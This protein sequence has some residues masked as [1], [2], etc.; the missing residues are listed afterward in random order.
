MTA[1]NA[2]P[3]ATRERLWRWAL[4]LLPG[5]ALVLLRG[6][7]SNWDLR[8]YHLYNPHAWLNGRMLTDIAPAQLQT[9][10][11]PL[12]DT[13]FYLLTVSGLD[14]RWASVWLT[15]PFAV[16]IYLLLGLHASLSP[17]RPSRCSQIVLA[18][19]AL[20]GAAFWSTLGNSM[21]D[22]FVAAA[23]LGALSL[24]LGPGQTRWRPWLWG[25]L[26]AGAMAGLKLTA[27]SYCIAL[28]VAALVPV[29]GRARLPALLALAAG[30]LLGFL[31]SYGWW[32]GTLYSLTRNPFFPYFNN[33]FHSSWLGA[34]D[35]ADARF[36]VHGLEGLLLAPFQLLRSSPLFSELYLRDPR[37]LLGLLGLG[38]LVLTRRGDVRLRQLAAFFFSAFIV[39]ALQYGIYRYAL[40]L[41]L[42]ASLAL[43]LCLQQLPRRWALVALIAAAVIVNVATKRQNWGHVH[44]SSPR[45]GIGAAPLLKDAM[46]IIAG[47]E[48]VAYLA[49]GLPDSTPMVA[50]ANNILSPGDCSDLQR[51]AGAAITRHEGS[52]WL[53]SPDTGHVA[54]SLAL[55]RAHYGL[56]SAGACLDYVSSLERAQLCPLKRVS[57]PPACR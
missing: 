4:A 24:V 41:E 3:V 13:P 36:R 57:G 31:V 42:L 32:G 35:F 55:L 43:V 25:G 17:T 50:V 14:M 29:P 18:L 6:V 40:T 19:L 47:G 39:W 11:N 5:L 1:E 23:M 10:H 38:W 8:N 30:G 12:L 49:I 45:L 21:N 56:D 7:D 9:W 51:R 37:L 28:A 34:Q 27:S 26:I 16:S 22:G 52:L 46:V 33:I 44:A 54:D 20:G 2:M 53:L 48:P 15:L